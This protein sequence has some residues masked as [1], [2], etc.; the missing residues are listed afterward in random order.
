MRMTTDTR[1]PMR[2]IKVNR[3]DYPQIRQ[4]IDQDNRTIAYNLGAADGSN[5]ILLLPQGRSIQA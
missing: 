2:K 3:P 4:I 1:Y 5:I